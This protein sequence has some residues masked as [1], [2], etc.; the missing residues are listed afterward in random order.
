VSQV[1]VLQVLAKDPRLGSMVAR[2]SDVISCFAEN[3]ELSKEGY[4]G[5]TRVLE[6]DRQRRVLKCLSDVSKHIT[7]SPAAFEDSNLQ[8][9]LVELCKSPDMVSRNLSLAC[10]KSLSDA[11]ASFARFDDGRIFAQPIT[12]IATQDDL[13]AA[14]REV[15]YPRLFWHIP[16]V[17]ACGTA[18]GTFREY[19]KLRGR[20]VIPMQNIVGNASRTGL[21]TAI[22]AS[23]MYVT[24]VH[25]MKFLHKHTTEI[26]T[27]PSEVVSATGNSIAGEFGMI[28]V[29]ST[30]FPHSFGGFVLG[31]LVLANLASVHPAAFGPVLVSGQSREKAY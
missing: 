11:G 21:G 2:D 26:C 14:S 18:Y 6:M 19:M 16:A 5:F 12:T 20:T 3:L 8:L 29:L 28:W 24:T 25:L 4:S 10:V 7:S 17:L 15:H 30:L 23:V 27:S 9:A 1:R 13:K 22:G 31:N